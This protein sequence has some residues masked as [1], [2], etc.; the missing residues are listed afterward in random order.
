M[1]CSSRERGCTAARVAYEME[2]LPAARVGLAEDAGDLVVE[3][4]VDRRL[5]AGVQLEVLG[6]GLDPVTERFDQRTVGE[7]GGEDAAREQDYAM[8]DSSFSASTS[9]TKASTTGWAGSM[10]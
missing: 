3:A 7:V 2:A 1:P 9:A 5:V 10:A 4:V 8:D 6:D